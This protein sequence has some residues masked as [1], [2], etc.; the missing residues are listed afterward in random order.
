M[1]F[2][3]FCV[4]FLCTIARS[5]CVGGGVHT[6]EDAGGSAERGGSSGGSATSDARDAGGRM[7]WRDAIKIWGLP[8]GAP[9]RILSYD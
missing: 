5:G 6:R 4:L 1:C 9:S 3:S 8:P 2:F 7:C